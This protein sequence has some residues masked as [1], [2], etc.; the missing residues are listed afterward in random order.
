MKTFQ[1]KLLLWLLLLLLLLFT[2]IEF[3]LGGSKENQNTFYVHY[4][5]PKNSRPFPDAEKHGTARQATERNILVI[6]TAHAL[7]M[8]DN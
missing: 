4:F 2:A 3:S 8:S 7:C 6:N 5:F 1:T